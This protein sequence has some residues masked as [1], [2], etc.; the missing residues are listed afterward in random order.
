MLTELVPSIEGTAKLVEEIS[1]ATQSQNSGAD[2]IN[3]SIRDLDAV[4][5]RNKEAASAARATVEVLS[6][7]AE[8]LT[9]IISQVD[10]TADEESDALITE[11][12]SQPEETP[13]GELK[14]A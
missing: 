4:I 8:E 12:S 13:G 10:D 3:Q 1:T 11:G 9:H 2:S 5:Q 7:Q 14:A 6:Q